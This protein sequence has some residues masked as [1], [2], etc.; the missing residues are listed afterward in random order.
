MKAMIAQGQGQLKMA[1]VTI[2]PTLYSD[3]MPFERFLPGF[4]RL[5]QRKASKII[6]EMA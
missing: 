2:L 4:E 1:E 3:R 5:K 6:F